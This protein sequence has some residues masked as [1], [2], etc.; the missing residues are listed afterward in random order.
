MIAILQPFRSM[1]AVTQHP[2]KSLSIVIHSILKANS[3]EPRKQSL[4]TEPICTSQRG[5]VSGFY[6][7]SCSGVISAC[8]LVG[9]TLRPS[10]PAR[11]ARTQ[12]TRADASRT[13]PYARLPRLR[14]RADA[15]ELASRCDSHGGSRKFF[16]PLYPGTSSACSS[17][18]P[19]SCPP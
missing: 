17:T 7:T 3:N 9:S 2:L 19:T 14:D 16:N 13:P 15:S 18:N 6:I 5:A 1:M 4:T 11:S 10:W 8:R 12:R